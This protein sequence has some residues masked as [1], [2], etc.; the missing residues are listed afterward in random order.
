MIMIH[1]HYNVTFISIFIIREFSN[2][3]LPNRSQQRKRR[4]LIVSKKVRPYYKV[5]VWLLNC[6]V[7]KRFSSCKLNK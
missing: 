2:N 7:I 5:Y 1:N 3:I 4:F 6:K